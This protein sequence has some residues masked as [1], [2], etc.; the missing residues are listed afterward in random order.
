MDVYTFD[1]R[2]L[3][4]VL[5][6][7][8]GSGVAEERLSE[9]VRQS[10]AINGEMFGPAPTQQIGNSGPRVQSAAAL[11]AAPGGNIARLGHGFMTVGRWWGLAGKRTIPIDDVQSVSLERVV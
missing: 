5:S 6:V 7:R 9:G 1:N 10:S 8:T 11:Y 2:Y 3:G 4:T